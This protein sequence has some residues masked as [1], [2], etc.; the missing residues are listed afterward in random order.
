MIPVL[1][2]LWCDGGNIAENDT[3]LG[4]FNKT[5][6]CCRMHDHCNNT[7]SSDKTKANLK[8]NGIFTR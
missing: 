4:S 1:G 6:A 3:D 5:D 8:N 7:I 2:T